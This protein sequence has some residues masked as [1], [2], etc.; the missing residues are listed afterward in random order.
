MQKSAIQFAIACIF[1]IEFSACKEK[2]SPNNKN[3]NPKDS[4]I[5]LELGS[6]VET[7]PT[8]TKYAPAFIGQTR[9]GSLKTKTLFQF[10]ILSSNLKDP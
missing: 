3:P 5:T 2:E 7:R 10:Q 4:T 8:V 9:V 1:L 6:P